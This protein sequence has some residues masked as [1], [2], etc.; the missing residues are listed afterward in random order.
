MRPEIEVLD[1]VNKQE[2]EQVRVWLSIMGIHSSIFAELNRKLSDQTGI[3]L[4][5]FDAMAQLDRYPEGISMGELSSALRVTNGNVSGLVSRLIKDDLVFREMSQEDRRSF[6]VKLTP[7]GKAKFA[8]A[9]KVH[10]DVLSD[11]FSKVAPEELSNTV[12]M[13]RNLSSK[14][15]LEA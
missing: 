15:A 12:K 4:T 5:K 6:R 1:H 13:L 10:Q 2:K 11:M 3:S 14:L 8:Q 9:L 7:T